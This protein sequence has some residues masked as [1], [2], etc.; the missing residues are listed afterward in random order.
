MRTLFMLIE[1]WEC[2]KKSYLSCV[3]TEPHLGRIIYIAPAYRR[4]GG[5]E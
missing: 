3:N 2:F 4:A 5:V 1:I